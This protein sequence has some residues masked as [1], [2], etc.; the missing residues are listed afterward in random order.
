M[1][2]ADIPGVKRSDLEITLEDGVLTVKGERKS[3]TDG[4]EEV[5]RRR[6]RIHGI[7]VRQFNLPDTV[8]TANISASAEDGVLRI[9]IPKQEKP[10]PRRITVS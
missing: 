8:D 3:E 1:L 2:T 7:F 9:A 4:T 6:E 10:E 5:Y